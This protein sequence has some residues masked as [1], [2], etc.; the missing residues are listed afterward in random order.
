M[1]T[2]FLDQQV[3]DELPET[4]ALE[5]KS[6]VKT[7]KE[8]KKVK[9]LTYELGGGR[10]FANLLESAISGGSIHQTTVVIVIDLSKPGNA[11][12]NLLYWINSVREQSQTVLE[13]LQTSNPEAFKSM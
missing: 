7:S 3:K 6:E 5:L 10:A 8:D 4:T 12:D 2:K 11:I 1:I 9:V 13:N